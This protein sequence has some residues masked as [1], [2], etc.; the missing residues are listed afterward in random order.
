MLDL[1]KK[2]YGAS[3]NLPSIAMAAA[4]LDVVVGIAMYSIFESVSV[5]WAKEQAGPVAAGAAS[6]AARHLLNWASGSPAGAA[7]IAATGSDVVVGAMVYAADGSTFGAAADGA[8]G[9][10]AGGLLDAAGGAVRRLLA[11]GNGVVDT[12]SH[13]TSWL[14][15]RGPMSIPLGIAATLLCGVFLGCTK[16]FNK[17]LRRTAATFSICQMLMFL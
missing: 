13:V 11:G 15:A 7:G 1:Q 17:P 10:A 4:G 5:S 8:A 6:S 14:V 2:G 3:I 9:S 16:L 12:G